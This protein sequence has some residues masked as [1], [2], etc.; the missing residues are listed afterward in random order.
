M[1]VSSDRCGGCII[2][3][4]ASSHEHE[5]NQDLEDDGTSPKDSSATHAPSCH[6]TSSSQSDHQGDISRCGE[7]EADFEISGAGVDKV[8]ATSEQCPA[9]D[10]LDHAHPKDEVVVHQHAKVVEGEDV[11]ALVLLL[12]RAILL[13][14]DIDMVTPTVSYIQPYS[15]LRQHVAV[16]DIL[17]HINGHSVLHLT[18]MELCSMINGVAKNKSETKLVFLPAK[19]RRKLQERDAMRRAKMKQSNRE[20]KSGIICT[21]IQDKDSVEDKVDRID[22]SIEQTDEVTSETSTRSYEESHPSLLDEVQPHQ[23]QYR[24]EDGSSN[25]RT[26]SSPCRPAPIVDDDTHLL[27]PIPSSPFKCDCSPIIAAS[28]ASVSSDEGRDSNYVTAKEESDDLDLSASWR[29]IPILDYLEKKCEVKNK[30]NQTA[31]GRGCRVLNPRVSPQ[32]E[33]RRIDGIHQPTVRHKQDGSIQIMCKSSNEFCSVKEPE[34][35]VSKDKSEECKEEKRATN[36]VKRNDVAEELR[37]IQ[38]DVLD[39]RD[40]RRLERKNRPQPKIE[41]LSIPADH[42]SVDDVSTLYGGVWNEQLHHAALRV[43]DIMLDHVEE[44][45]TRQDTAMNGYTEKR[46]IRGVNSHEYRADKK[47]GERDSSRFTDV[48]IEITLVSVCIL[49]VIGLFAFLFIVVLR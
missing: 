45:V 31:Q 18:H 14:I 8:A 19:Y 23:G 11:Q 30:N 42:D 46:L 3:P 25:L 12:P 9:S 29:G 33:N 37:S 26:P 16:G 32:K 44:G 34:R 38:D 10:E 20:Q 47:N 6:S 41:F 27:T 7:I 28:R 5:L 49:S 1:F 13:G 48:I 21:S 17:I 24:E 22:E 4:H 39:D 43:E 35:Y 15:P 36:T 2:T 40:R